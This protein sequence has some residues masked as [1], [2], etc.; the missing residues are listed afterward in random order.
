MAKKNSWIKLSRNIL[1]WRWYKDPNTKAM[2]I[3]LLLKANVE[4]H[5][6][7]NVTVERG[8]LATSYKTLATEVGL[9]IQQ[10]RTT[11]MHLKDTGEITLNQHGRFSVISIPQYDSYQSKSATNQQSINTQPTRELTVNQQQSKNIRNKELIKEKEKIKEKESQRQS[12]FTPPTVEEVA[13]YCQERGNTVDAQVFID[14]YESK[15]W[16]VGKNRMKD[17]KAAVRTWERRERREPAQKQS[18]FSEDF[19]NDN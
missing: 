3:H 11:L 9:T 6:F 7:M 4:P 15:G 13:A 17:W 19:W 8:E 10:V 5:D 18:V 1:D 2:F 16:M 12:R 14:F